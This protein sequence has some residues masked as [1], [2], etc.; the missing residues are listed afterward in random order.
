MKFLVT[1]CFVTILMCVCN[2]LMKYVTIVTL[3]LV[4]IE[5]WLPCDSLR[6]MD[7]LAGMG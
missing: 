7:D 1:L 6:P 5:M 2:V 3:C 4:C